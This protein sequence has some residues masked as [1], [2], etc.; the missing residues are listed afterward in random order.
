M[1]F[2]FV[3]LCFLQVSRLLVYKGNM[4]T[5][6]TLQSRTMV[7]PSWNWSYRTGSQVWEANCSHPQEQQKL[8]TTEPCLHPQCCEFYIIDL[9]RSFE[10]ETLDIERSKYHLHAVYL[11]R[12]LCTFCQH[13]SLR[14]ILSPTSLLQVDSS[15]LLYSHGLFQSVAQ[16]FLDSISK[17]NRL[18][19]NNKFE[20]PLRKFQN[21]GLDQRKVPMKEKEEL[22]RTDV[23]CFCFAPFSPP[24]PTL[25][26][27]PL[28]TLK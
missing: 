19:R 11:F 2:V 4:C 27:L 7:L 25:S 18:Q 24:T 13:L 8:V 21:L 12:A 16:Q 15:L 14:H 23:R 17:V 20:V 9:V 3:Y 1:R 26:F 6:G 22:D 28:Q 5:P 10:K